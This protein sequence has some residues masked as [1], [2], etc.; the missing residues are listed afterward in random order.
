MFQTVVL[1][2]EDKDM[3]VGHGPIDGQLEHHD[4]TSRASTR[5]EL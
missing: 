2:I 4:S 1:S 5:Q 3:F